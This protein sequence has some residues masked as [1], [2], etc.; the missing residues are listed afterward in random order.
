MSCDLIFFFYF[1]FL[2]A[3]STAFQNKLYQIKDLLKFNK[4]KCSVL[5]HQ[6]KH[7]PVVHGSEYTIV[8][9]FGGCFAHVNQLIVCKIIKL[10]FLLKD[11]SATMEKCCPGH[12]NVG[13]VGTIQR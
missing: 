2:S 7:S 1:F 11:F 4:E 6:Y 3:K 9:E 5:I 10:M 12:T 13:S 8:S